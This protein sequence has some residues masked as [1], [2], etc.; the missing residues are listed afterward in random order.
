MYLSLRTKPTIEAGIV[1]REILPDGREVVGYE[2]GDGT[3]YLLIISPLDGFAMLTC[4]EVGIDPSLKNV[5]VTHASD[6]GDPRSLITYRGGHLHYE[7]VKRLLRTT[8]AS[9]I[10]LAEVIAYLIGGTAL[11]CD[12]AQKCFEEEV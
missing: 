12:E 2:P 5:I 1:Y 4:L 9:A 3:R 8:L 7:D 11:S 6:P 10:T